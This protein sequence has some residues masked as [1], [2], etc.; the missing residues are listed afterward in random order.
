[1]YRE[2][3]GTHNS[4]VQQGIWIRS[5]CKDLIRA[6]ESGF[7]A[8]CSSREI[9]DFTLVCC[10]SCRFRNPSYHDRHWLRR[11][12]E[13]LSKPL[14]SPS[15]SSSGSFLNSSTQSNVS[16]SYTDTHDTCVHA[17]MESTDP[18]FYQ[19]ALYVLLRSPF[20]S[21]RVLH[22]ARLV[23]FAAPRG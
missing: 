8:L 10:E 15:L 4:S 16:Y 9:V 7:R 5:L 11:D 13:P 12:N 22:L 19:R 17:G 6:K 23:S 20:D 14:N 1:M 18:A 2:C 21:V 3:Y